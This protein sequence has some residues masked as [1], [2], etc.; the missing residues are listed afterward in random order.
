MIATQRI[1][2]ATLLLAATPAI[3]QP[4]P[5]VVP[6]APLARGEGGIGPAFM[7]AMFGNLSPEGRAVVRGSLMPL[8]DDGTRAEIQAVR[9]RILDVLDAERLDT[10]ALQRAM[11]EERNLTQ[12]QQ[13]RVQTAML[14]A[15]GK[16]S[17]A[18]R[19][20]LVAS[21]RGMKNRFE[22]RRARWRDRMGER[23]PQ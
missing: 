15:F 5:P 6:S 13:S 9:A 2:L 20:A 8:K 23:S 18:D 12:G 3:A 7:R 22:E 4:A 16:L 14:A 19:R 11:L 21:A 17:V 10:G 1:G